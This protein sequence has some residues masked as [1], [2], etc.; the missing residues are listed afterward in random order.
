MEA[1]S[2]VAFARK[3]LTDVPVPLLPEVPTSAKKGFP[4][5]A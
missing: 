2:N 1:L 5:S 3:G 4:V